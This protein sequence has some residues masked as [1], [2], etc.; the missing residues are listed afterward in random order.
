MENINNPYTLSRERQLKSNKLSPKSTNWLPLQN[1]GAYVQQKIGLVSR[2]QQPY[3][4]FPMGIQKAKIYHRNPHKRR[5]H[6]KTTRY[7]NLLRSGEGLWDH[8]EVWYNDTWPNKTH[9]K[10]HSHIN[11]QRNTFQHPRNVTQLLPYLQ[12]WF[13]KRQSNWMWCSLGK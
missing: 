5:Q 1:Y 6:P 9:Q 11:V 10:E 7:D 13:Q 4:Q 2:I 8:L 12:R 3:N